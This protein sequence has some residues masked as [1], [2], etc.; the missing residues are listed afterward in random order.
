MEDQKLS[1]N[2]LDE[3]VNDIESTQLLAKEFGYL[4]VSAS[5]SLD[6]AQELIQ[7][8]KQYKEPRF[9]GWPIS[10]VE[11]YLDQEKEIPKNVLADYHAHMNSLLEGDDTD[12]EFFIDEAYCVNLEVKRK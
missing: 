8:V 2:S 9:F 11:L 7:A 1:V 3:L 12:Q 4:A 5:M 10:L 6:V